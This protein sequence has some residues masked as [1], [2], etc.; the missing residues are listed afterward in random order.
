[1]PGRPPS[2]QPPPSA[3]PS[4][5]AARCRGCFP[6][7]SCARSAG[8][9]TS[10]SAPASS[11]SAAAPASPPIRNCWRRW[12]P[13]APAPTISASRCRSASRID[14]EGRITDER[15]L[16]QILTSWDRLQRLLRATIDPAH[17]HL[18][19]AFERVEQNGSGVRVHFTG[20]RI[21]HADILIG[22]DGIRSSV[23]GQVAPELQP[24]YAGYYIWRGAPNEA[25]LA[26]ETLKQNLSAVHV[27]PAE[28]PAGDHLP[29]LRLQQRSA[30]RPSPLQFHL[31]SRRRRRADARDVRRRERHA[32]RIFGAAAAHPQGPD[33]AE[34]TRT[35][36]RSCRRRCSTA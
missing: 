25:D 3:G 24:I 18:G 8:T 6:P 4:S 17:Y 28:A 36:A 35:R 10:T 22:G 13:A 32:A 14:R 20:G 21:E 12:K 15:P 29:D 1:M 27:L 19:W 26:P 11:W 2:A 7:R 30:A 23:R 16:R 31:V 33:R 9:S 34:C 5:S